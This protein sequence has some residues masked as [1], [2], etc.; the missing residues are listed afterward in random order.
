[1]NGSTAPSS[2]RVPLLKKSFRVPFNVEHDI[3]SPDLL[4]AQAFALARQ[5]FCR[6]AD[7]LPHNLLPILSKDKST[8]NRTH[9]NST[10]HTIK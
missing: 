2:F 10:V 4:S 9:E 5:P 1:M 3:A 7:A 6:V 8:E